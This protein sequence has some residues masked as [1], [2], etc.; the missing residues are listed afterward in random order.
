MNI[1]FKKSEDYKKI[2][3]FDTAISGRILSRES[4]W[5]EFKESFNWNSNDKYAKSMAAFANNKGGY[6][7]FGV[8]DK[9]RDMVGLQSNNFES[10][11]EAK[12]SSYLNSNFSPEIHFEKFVISVR[13]KSIGILYTYQAK[14]KPIVCLKNDGDLKEADIYYR[15]N[16]RSERAKYP[17]I[18][19]I[20]EIVKEDE[21]K[22]WMEHFEKISKIG[23]SKVAIMD[24]VHGEIDGSKGTLIIDKK[25]IPKLRFIN[26]GSFK[27]GGK[28]VLRLIG[29]VKPVTFHGE[30]GSIDSTNI[31]ITD[32]INA[33]EVRLEEDELLKK[34]YPLDYAGLTDE[35]NKRYADFKINQEYHKIRKDLM[36]DSN[37]CKRRYLN[38]N[39]NNS[40]SQD[41]YSRNII[42][43]FDKYYTKRK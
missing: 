16:A 13:K 37:L 29:D 5:L 8:K 27:E 31:K 7:V 35:L 11:D 18:K 43:K 23:P 41:F 17:E 6:I 28:T 42:S 30:K 12:I 39:K 15:Y 26:E 40:S 38:P 34:K 4:G 33:L 10:T 32:D 14:S 3:A 1:N 9:P 36:K 21:R 25:L 2:F 22:I 19:K 20:F 24:T